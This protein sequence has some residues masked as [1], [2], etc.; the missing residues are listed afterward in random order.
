[1]SGHEHESVHDAVGAYV[2]GVLDDTDASVFETHLVGCDVCA[3][4]LEELSGMEPVLA[5]L[6]PATPPRAPA[7]PGGRVLEGLLAEVAGQRAARRRRALCLIAVAGALI[8]GGPL[9]AVVVTADAAAPAAQAPPAEDTSLRTM[10]AKVT[11][12]DSTTR[13]RATV[14]T[15]EREWGTHTVLELRNVTGPL[16]CSLIAVS[17]S[18][19]EEIV[20]SWA[21]PRRGY[22]PADGPNGTSGEPLYVHGGAAMPRADIDRFEV[23]TF[24]GRKLVEVDA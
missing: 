12:T 13:V 19:E 23:R 11:A 3:A 21:V 20:A 22:G 2:L 10:D 5:A 18:G 15:E 4:R 9:T 7:P 24:D 14:G 6:P 1:M 8:V 17:R 16:K